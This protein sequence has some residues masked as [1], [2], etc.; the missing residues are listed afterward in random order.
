[1]PIHFNSIVLVASHNVS[2]L[3]FNFKNWFPQIF[4]GIKKTVEVAY[5]FTK[6]LVSQE[7]VSLKISRRQ[8]YLV[9]SYRSLIF[10]HFESTSPGI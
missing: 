3:T 10:V 5:L 2:F 9:V 8:H 7:A 4:L 6:H 1:M